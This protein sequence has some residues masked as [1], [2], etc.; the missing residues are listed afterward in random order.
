M[1][2]AILCGVDVALIVIGNNKLT[3]YSSGDMDQL[4]LRYTDGGFDEPQAEPLTNE[5][6]SKLYAKKNKNSGAK[7]GGSP[8]KKA[9]LDSP[10]LPVPVKPLAAATPSSEARASPASRNPPTPPGKPV[11]PPGA[12][13]SHRLATAA[14][15]RL[16]QCHQSNH[17]HGSS[18]LNQSSYVGYPSTCSGS[19]PSP[20]SVPGGHFAPPDRSV[21]TIPQSPPPLSPLFLA[22]WYPSLTRLAM[23]GV[24]GVS[25]RLW[26]VVALVRQASL[27]PSLKVADAPRQWWP[28]P[29][30]TQN[31]WWQAPS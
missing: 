1:E 26:L 28:P 4:L 21:R 22:T 13:S 15:S 6:Y 23:D 8:A 16:P 27:S 3:Q 11:S 19:F 20:F 24:T 5:D 12:S 25:P 31:F 10:T 7:Q 2:L 18:A 29:R 30:G 14:P 9:R 17:Q